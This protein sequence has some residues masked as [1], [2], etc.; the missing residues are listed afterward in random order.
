MYTAWQLL[1]CKDNKDNCDEM[2]IRS[3]SMK[4]HLFFSSNYYQICDAT[5]AFAPNVRDS[6]AQS[7]P[8]ML[9]ACLFECDG[10]IS[11]YD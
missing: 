9:Y 7:I 4:C 11:F 5:M 3:L 2:N 8:C 1:G 6:N 10:L